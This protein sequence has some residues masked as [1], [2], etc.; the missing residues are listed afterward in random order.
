MATRL[1]EIRD[2]HAG[3][4]KAEIIHG[5]TL[6]ADAGRITGLIGPNGAGKTTVARTIAGLLK[7][8]SGSISLDGTPLDDRNPRA[9]ALLGLGYTPQ[10]GN[11]FTDLTVGDN[12]DLV[13]RTFGVPA[14]RVEAV[15]DDF[16]VLRER[17]RQRAGTLSGGER[18]QLAIACSLQMEPKLLVL[19][20]P[21]S[22]LAPLIVTM[23]VDKILEI[24]GGRG[25]G[26]LW[27]VEEHPTQILP[28]CDHVY[29][30]ESGQIRHEASGRELLDDPNFAELF[31]GA[32]ISAPER[33]EE[34]SGRRLEA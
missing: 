14:E 29:L 19:D 30:L 20:E 7:P 24:C 28:Y 13:K 21:T 9:R 15:L 17:L 12:L 16:P 8:R 34:R 4:G 31:L 26:I 2:L 33:L 6:G 23:L 27:I 32:D 5:V 1:L 18:Q 25:A 3:Y 11:V 10:E 22:G